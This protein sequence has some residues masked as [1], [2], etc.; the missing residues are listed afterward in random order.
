ML[1][2]NIRGEEE[3]MNLRIDIRTESVHPRPS[4]EGLS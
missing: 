1:I 3:S 2:I 4:K